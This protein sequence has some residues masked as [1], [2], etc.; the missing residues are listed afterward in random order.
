MYEWFHR[1][2]ISIALRLGVEEMKPILNGWFV[3]LALLLTAASA[4]AQL[5]AVDDVTSVPFGQALTVEA[6]G[7]LDNDTWNGEPAGENGASAS[8]VSDVSHG[9]LA[10]GPDG[11]FTYTPGL[12]RL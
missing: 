2:C 4:Q 3:G 11:S 6:F 5:V 9:A 7:V 1:P 10:M 12:H 8:L